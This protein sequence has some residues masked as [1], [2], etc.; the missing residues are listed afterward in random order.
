MSNINM[1]W[2]AKVCLVKVGRIGF[3]QT[4]VLLIF[5]G[6]NGQITMPTCWPSSRKFS[7][8]SMCLW[9][10]T[11]H[12]QLVSIASFHITFPSILEISG[13]IY[14]YCMGVGIIIVTL[15]KHLRSSWI[16]RFTRGNGW[17]LA[18]NKRA[19]ISKSQITVDLVVDYRL[20]GDLSPALPLGI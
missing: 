3:R 15:T 13:V 4:H 9:L 8:A 12:F 17:N 14:R 7:V 6:T 1:W 10:R 16:V 11:I 20:E 18:V 5:C 19:G 2:L